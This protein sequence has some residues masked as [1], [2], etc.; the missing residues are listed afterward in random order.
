M[1]ARTFVTNDRA[2]IT[3]DG[4]LMVLGRMDAAVKIRGYLV[5]PAEVEA[6]MLDCP[7][8]REALVVADP[9]AE[10]PVLTAYVA[11]TPGARSPAVADVRAQLHTRLPAWMVPTH[12]VMLEAL[13]RN[14]R[15]KVDRRALPAPVRGPIVPPAPGLETEI[16]AAWAERAAPRR[17]RA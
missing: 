10:T 4:I 1:A 9:L 16:A 5:E 7:G 8:I 17:G 12:V 13:P 3:E 15:G 2:R 6:A 11:P 14:E